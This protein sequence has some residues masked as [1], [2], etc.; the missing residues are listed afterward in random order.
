VTRSRSEYRLAP[1]TC[2]RPVGE[3]IVREPADD[4]REALAT[5]LL[6]GY[7]G[8]VDDEGE[9]H[10]DALA[11][12]DHYVHLLV[13]PHSI[14]VHDG[15][16]LVAIVRRRRERRALHRPDR[17]RAASDACRRSR[18]GSG[19]ALPVPAPSSQTTP[20]RNHGAIAA[21]NSAARAS[22]PRGCS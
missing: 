13:R 10:E 17:R 6:D 21:A 16:D 4:D 20:S 12:I 18:S 3:L 11:A 1:V 14:V 5:L 8:S 7:R 2:G 15:S 19:S 22:P 9:D